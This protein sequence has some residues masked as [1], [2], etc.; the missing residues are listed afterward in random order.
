ML[1][2]VIL[3]VADKSRSEML[4]EFNWQ[5]STGWNTSVIGQEH[6]TQTTALDVIFKSLKSLKSD[7][8]NPKWAGRLLWTVAVPPFEGSSL[9]AASNLVPLQLF[10][11]QGENRFTSNT[12]CFAP[13]PFLSAATLSSSPRWSALSDFLSGFLYGELC[14]FWSF[15]TAASSSSLHSASLLSAEL[16]FADLLTAASHIH[17]SVIG[18]APSR[19]SLTWS[20]AGDQSFGSSWVAAEQACCVFAVFDDAAASSISQFLVYFNKCHQM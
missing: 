12:A 4:K 17:D 6:H 8:K 10:L 1:S 19:M 5:L 15:C 16:L 18:W 9:H 3:D 13:P 20:S 7:W 14:F 11:H 2:A